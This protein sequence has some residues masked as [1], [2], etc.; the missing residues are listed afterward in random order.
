MANLEHVEKRIEVCLSRQFIRRPT[1]ANVSE[2]R[3]RSIRTS[4]ILHFSYTA[5]RLKQR[6]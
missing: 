1:Q 5:S 2:K 6:Y 4:I 3:L